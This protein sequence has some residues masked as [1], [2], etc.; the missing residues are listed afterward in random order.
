M[1]PLP[2][3]G[4]GMTASYIAANLVEPDRKT[5]WRMQ[6]IKMFP[7][8]QQRFLHHILDVSRRYPS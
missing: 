5:F 6:S 7:G 2:G 3:A 8:F 4:T 1:T